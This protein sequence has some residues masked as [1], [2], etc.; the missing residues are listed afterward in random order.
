MK[1]LYIYNKVYGVV[2]VKKICK[3]GRFVV[4]LWRIDVRQVQEKGGESA[5][6][7]VEMYVRDKTMFRFSISD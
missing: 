2:Y 3:I 6:R 7:C 1:S 5:G 4:I